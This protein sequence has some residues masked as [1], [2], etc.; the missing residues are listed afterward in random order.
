MCFLPGALML[1]LHVLVLPASCYVIDSYQ[2]VC[3]AFHFILQWDLNYICPC[4]MICTVAVALLH[5]ALL[6]SRNCIL[7][8]SP[9]MHISDEAHFYLV[10]RG[11]SVYT[12]GLPFQLLQRWM[13][14]S[15]FN[16]E[17]SN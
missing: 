5:S 6:Y 14:S 17:R 1:R 4:G 9:C 8:M 7:E 13:V 2:P 12:V 3:E 11:I 16:Q 10:S 15:N